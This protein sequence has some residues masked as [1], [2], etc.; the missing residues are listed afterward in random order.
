MVKNPPASE[1]TGETRAR[2]P[3]GEDPLEEVMVTHSRI[4]ARRPRGQK[5]LAGYHPCHKEL[6]MTDAT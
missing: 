1:E 3:G 4:L 5:S 6:D 2:F